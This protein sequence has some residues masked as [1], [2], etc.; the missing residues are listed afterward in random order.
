MNNIA[1]AIINSN[2]LNNAE[3]VEA[4]VAIF[5][6]HRNHY[7]QRDGRNILSAMKKDVPYSCAEIA[8]GVKSNGGYETARGAASIL[9]RYVKEGLV[10]RTYI[11]T[12]KVFEIDNPRVVV[13][14]EKINN[15]KMY[16]WYE[17]YSSAKG[18]IHTG[19]LPPEKFIPWAEA[20]LAETK[21]TI[22]IEEKK[23]VY[24]RLF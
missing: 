13:L 16:H 20:L 15:C 2:E 17:D 6:S 8:E 5:G 18:D 24:T 12:G 7:S 9:R 1:N 22:T 19:Y 14:E 11:K 10:E 4:M 23:A 3:K 21:P